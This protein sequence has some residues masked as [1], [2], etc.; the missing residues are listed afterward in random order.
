[1]G[2]TMKKLKITFIWLSLL[3]IAGSTAMT[4]TP[5][6][7]SDLTL[8]D[9]EVEVQQ[10]LSP[11]RGEPEL[12]EESHLVESPIMTPAPSIQAFPEP[13]F[14][15]LEFSDHEMDLRGHGN[16]TVRF[17]MQFRPTTERA[18][19][20]GYAQL[21]TSDNSTPVSSNAYWDAWVDP[22][23]ITV[24]SFDISGY[25]IRE[26]GVNG[27][28]SVRLGFY[29]NNGSTYTIYNYEFVH[30]SQAY[31]YTD[32][33]PRPTIDSYTYSAI[34]KDL[35]GLYEWI[36]VHI[37]V[38]VSIPDTYYFSGNIQPTSG[39]VSED[40]RND[41]YLSVGTHTVTLRFATWV[42]QS[43][44][45]PDTI[46]LTSFNMEHYTNPNY[47]I[48]S[49]NPSVS[50]GSYAPT[51]FDDP[52]IDLTGNYWGQGYDTDGNGLYN[53]YRFN[54]EVNKTRIEEGQFHLYAAVYQPPNSH[55]TG[56][57]AN[58]D[59]TLRL[60]KIGLTNITIDFNGIEIYKSG[61][62]NINLIVKDIQGY[63]NHQPD[64]GYN[65]D[66]WFSFSLVEMISVGIY[67]YTD[68]EG[69]GA[70]LTHNF[71]DNGTD[72]DGDG[73]FN[74]VIVEVEVNVTVEGDYYLSSWLDI[75]ST[76]QD[77]DYS[78]TNVHLTVGTHWVQLQYD[79]DAFF[80]SA[81]NDYV[82]LEYLRLRGGYPE[83][84][85]DYNNTAVLSHYLFTD[86]DPPKA[87]FTGIYSDTTEDT[88]SDGLWD[89]LKITVEVEINETGRYRVQG[90]IRNPITGQGRGD[91]TVT[92]EVG[93]AGTVPFV[94]VFPGSWIW[95]QHTNTTYILS[96]VSI[97]EVDEFNNYIK[98]WDY[99]ND[100]FTT[101]FIYD[102]NDFNAPPG[103]FTGNF[104]ETLVDSD[105]DGLSDYLVIGVEIEVS[106][107]L[108][109]RVEGYINLEYDSVWGYA[110][111]LTLSAGTHEIELEFM[112]FQL[113]AT[114]KNQTYDINFN[115]YRTDNWEHLD[116]FSDYVTANYDYT[117]FDPPR[118]EFTGNFFDY[119]VD[120]DVPAN[121]RFDYVQ[122]AFE[123]NVIENGSFQI[124]G[125]ISAVE[126]GDSF[127]F[128]G[129]T[130]ELLPGQQ[131]VTVN[132]EAYW[133][134]GHSS[135]FS[136]YV[137]YVYLSEYIDGYGG[138][139]LARNEEDRPLANTYYHEDFDLPPI[140]FTGFVYDYGI[141][142]DGNGKFDFLEFAIEVNV[143]E[144]GTYYLSGNVYCDSGGNS[145]YFYSDSMQLDVGLHNFTFQIEPYWIRNHIDGSSFY[146]AYMYLY[147]Y[148]PSEG[149]I[150]RGYTDDDQYFSGTYYHNDF[151]LPD[152]WI[153]GILDQYPIDFSGDGKYDVYRVIYIVNVTV[154]DLDLYIYT[155][156]SEQDT[157]SWI[158]SSSI[159]LYGLSYGLHNI[160][161]D[162]RGNDLYSSGFSKGIQ[163]S[164]YELTRISDWVIVDR[165][166]G[167]IPLTNTYT[168]DDFSPDFFALVQIYSIATLVNEFGQ[169]EVNV[170]II[171]Y[172]SETVDWVNL[173]TEYGWYDMSRVMEVLNFE[174]WS[175]TYSPP[176]TD[177]YSFTVEVRGNWGS[178]DSVSLVFGGPTFDEFQVNSTYG[179]L[180][181][182]FVFS[183]RVIDSDGI[184]DV[185]LNLDGTEYPMTFIENV[186]NVELWQ[187]NVTISQEGTIG[188]FA[189]AT[190]QFGSSSDS[191][192][193]TL[194]IDAGR[195]NII[196]FTLNT[197]LPITVGG[198]IHFEAL[199]R[200]P[201]GVA[202]VTLTALGKDYSMTEI[203]VSGEI[204]AVDVTFNDAGQYSAYIVATDENGVT[205][206][207]E[208]EDIIVNEGSV[209][210]DVDIYP[211][212]QVDI[213]TEISFT[214]EIQK[215]DAIITS[216][217]LEII[218][219]R[220]NEY[221]VPLEMTDETDTTEIYG[222]EYTPTSA[223]T[224]ECTIRVLNTRNQESI[225][226]ETITVLSGEDVNITPGFN[227]LMVLGL[228]VVI[229]MSGRRHRKKQR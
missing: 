228:L 106:Q 14:E 166:S 210:L 134:L 202:S 39:G 113:H 126:G 33:Q 168:S 47:Y 189:T 225:Y 63:F 70:Y 146:I 116:S 204:W 105:L 51:D 49:G 155:Y 84:E 85:L 17:N 21:F 19:Y 140:A 181:D 107:T 122:L 31:L 1:M 169:V 40:A 11:L 150:Q 117:E 120:S 29:K 65:W 198:T 129:D 130:I 170:T 67:D 222:G 165:L 3:L 101:D 179:M 109:I 216:V 61:I 91:D 42:F 190:D 219:N 208:D 97:V 200:D 163:I 153:V 206:Q 68:F 156:L 80:S 223:G 24:A 22:N 87:R 115:L 213:D 180:G 20:Y 9:S 90:S 4:I 125:R 79:G 110:D 207:S 18:S 94:L 184:G 77:I 55:I 81:V 25:E 30:M 35:N 124:Y 69:P 64:I 46:N 196:F 135:G 12:M 132:V 131:N 177:S 112:T 118:A 41:T 78:G 205:A 73:L 95:S 114:S 123:V 145:F 176:S 136:A 54:I 92:K 75:S 8:P 32:F 137:D 23:T 199:V 102:S 193:I 158:T 211:G 138:V 141:D 27:P 88:N 100:P 148:I 108:D 182:T 201:D 154:P 185:V 13:T 99:R 28:Y 7:I 38:T 160:T 98:E 96:Y 221:L 220:G 104:N 48:Y 45:G 59:T 186:S 167:E 5:L 175:F 159:Y 16:D 226:V 212:T 157:Y 133:F 62:V 227:L 172:S 173:Q 214:I 224:Y 195:P 15:V 144:A 127:W 76:G 152:A 209:I 151:D 83:T 178:V 162:F 188:A 37:T 111:E 56:Q 82:K 121:G 60:D 2:I 217:T 86:F 53:F 6:G 143:T 58:W 147:Q 57:W 89:E 66:D 192:E 119:G 161:I 103:F 43:M 164:S 215:S 187:V 72:T 139:T 218:D 93:A 194:N 34:D 71:K 149:S 197:S 174:L 191:D 52:P 10:D 203:D 183:A 74:F 44:S 229:G 26:S 142:T 50:L 171:R 128:G 36:D